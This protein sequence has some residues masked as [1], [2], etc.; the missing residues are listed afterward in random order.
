MSREPHLK[1][2]LIH[3]LK[4]DPS[5]VPG[6]LYRNWPLGSLV[7]SLRYSDWTAWQSCSISCGEGLLGN[8]SARNSTPC[9]LPKDSLSLSLSKTSNC[10]LLH[11]CTVFVR[12]PYTIILC[13]SACRLNSARLTKTWPSGTYWAEPWRCTLHR[14]RVRLVGW[15]VGVSTWV[16]F[17]PSPLP[18]LPTYILYS[19]LVLFLLLVS[20]RGTASH[21][22]VSRILSLLVSFL[23][24]SGWAGMRG[25]LICLLP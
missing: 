22:L 21:P 16:P 2:Y 7:E 8:G 4:D 5:H 17:V 13:Q 19:I 23:I 24:G 25:F 6:L 11:Y 3:F 12:I 9:L 20:R 15:W 14:C 1:I 10:Y 18:P